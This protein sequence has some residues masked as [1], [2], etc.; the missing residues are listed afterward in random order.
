[1]AVGS[2]D[3]H[4]A[5]W[6]HAT[7]GTWSLVSTAALAGLT[8]R[9]TSVAEGPSGWIAVGSM[10]ENGTAGPAAF[11]RPDGGTGTPPPAPPDPPG[12]RPPHLRG[13]ARPPRN[14]LRGGP[15]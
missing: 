4:P 5:V 8:G 9:L 15:R 2:A 10:K 7:D 1:M 13:P 6:R 3:A 14:A 11:W 12:P